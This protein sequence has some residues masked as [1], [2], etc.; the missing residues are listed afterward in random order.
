MIG[1]GLL[2]HHD[3][4]GGFKIDL[5]GLTARAP[6]KSGATVMGKA[7]QINAVIELFNNPG[8]AAAGCGRRRS[9]AA[10]C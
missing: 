1:G 5:C 2:Q 8:F 6:T 7:F 10:G 4:Q 9:P 3:R